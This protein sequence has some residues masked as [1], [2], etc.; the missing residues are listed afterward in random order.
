MYT[1]TEKESEHNMGCQHCPHEVRRLAKYRRREGK[2]TRAGHPDEKK[3]EEEKKEKKGQGGGTRGQK[4]ESAQNLQR[5][6]PK[7]KASKN[8]SVIAL[9]HK[10]KD[11][12]P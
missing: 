7:H 12:S 10:F 1:Y 2:R 11:R 6:K 8:P 4:W 5:R 9:H 3:K